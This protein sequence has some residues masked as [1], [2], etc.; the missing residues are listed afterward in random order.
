G[1][2]G[3][4]DVAGA[5]RRAGRDERLTV[6]DVGTHGGDH[7]LRGLR[8]RTEGRRIGHV[9]LHERELRVGLPQA[10]PYVLELARVAPRQRPARVLAGVLGEIFGGQP[11]REARGSE[12]DHVVLAV[13]H[14]RRPPVPWSAPGGARLPPWPRPSTPPAPRRAR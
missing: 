6:V 7:D 8:E 5:G 12:Q 1:L 11:A 14:R 4:I 3:E 10:P 13:S 2:A 9:R